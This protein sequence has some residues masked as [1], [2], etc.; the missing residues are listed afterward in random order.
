MSECP[1]VAVEDRNGT[2]RHRPLHP[3]L[4]TLAV[5]F[6][7]LLW[8]AADAHA[9]RDM[10]IR[11]ARDEC[12]LRGGQFWRTNLGYGCNETRRGLP[13]KCRQG[14]CSDG[15]MTTSEPPR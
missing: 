11:E 4:L 15:H 9:V 12:V 1:Q 6:G 14:A 3:R 7:G 2:G 13:F 5:A 10:G 8:M